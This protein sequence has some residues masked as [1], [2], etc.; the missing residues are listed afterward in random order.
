[1]KKV[2]EKGDD[3]INTETSRLSRMLGELSC[4]KATGSMK[5]PSYRI[6]NFPLK[7]KVRFDTVK[8]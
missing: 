1:M 2:I 3:F 7:I 6:N 5:C 8:N 4:F